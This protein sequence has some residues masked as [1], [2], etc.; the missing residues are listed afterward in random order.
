MSS[1]KNN[2]TVACGRECS[3]SVMSDTDCTVG[4]R[5]SLSHTSVATN[6]LFAVMHFGV[7][8]RG[9]LYVVYP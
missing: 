9:Y 8:K 3:C 7:E 5:Q 6:S 1:T 2:V 4:L